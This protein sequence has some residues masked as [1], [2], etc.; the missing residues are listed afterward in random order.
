M[1]GQD[2]RGSARAVALALAAGIAWVA[3]ATPGAPLAAEPAKAARATEPAGAAWAAEPAWAAESVEPARAVE[4]AG[5]ARAAGAAESNAGPRPAAAPAGSWTPLGPPAAGSLASFALSPQSARWIYAASG[6]GTRLY[7]T[8]D[9]GATWASLPVPPPGADPYTQALQLVV[10]PLAP[11]TVYVPTAASSLGRLSYTLFRTADGGVSWTALPIGPSWVAV[12][13]L[14][15]QILYAGPPAV[16]SA[17]AGATWMA[18]AG[19]PPD[20]TQIVIDPAS[21]ATAYALPNA[22]A[23]LYKST[24]RGVT[25]TPAGDAIGNFTALRVDPASPATLYAAAGGYLEKSIDGG[26][27]WQIVYRPA[28]PVGHGVSAVA[29]AR[30]VPTSVYGVVAGT[31]VVRS[32]DGGTTW[33]ALPTAALPG[34]VLGL[35]VDPQDPLRLIAN[36][37]GAGLETLTLPGPCTPGAEALCLGTGGRFRVTATWSAASTAGA[38]KSFGLTADTGAFWFFAPA[39]LELVVKVIDG[40]AVNGHHWVFAGGLTDV[41]VIVTATDTVTGQSRSYANPAGVPFPPLQATSAF[42]TCP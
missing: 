15:D 33:S 37:D 14:Q 19:L 39:N 1:R 28:D 35:E 25:W 23:T 5:A 17:D 38:G 2:D 36:V 27:I 42:A 18:L 11:T 4:P 21:P 40:C 32:A 12:D 41:G 29:V 31:G 26:V 16:R 20:V 7:A 8:Q 3:L 9:G 10:D 22:S 6:D 30:T 13:P 34:A 24:D